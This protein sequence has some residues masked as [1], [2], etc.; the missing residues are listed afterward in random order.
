MST[1]LFIVAGLIVLVIVT[2]WVAYKLGHGGGESQAV[3]DLGLNGTIK[4]PGREAIP[5][6]PSLVNNELKAPEPKAAPAERKPNPTPVAPPSAPGTDPRVSGLNYYL[7]ASGLDKDGAQKIADFLTE[8]GLQSA[9]AVDRKP[10]GSN[11]PGSYVV[12]VT[13]GIKPEEYKTRAAART[14]VET[15]VSR[16]GKVWQKERKGKT[17]FSQAYWQRYSN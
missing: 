10:T 6:N 14:E 8:N 11:N 16:L 4:E 1:V 15:Q 12:F 9:A 13:R 2:W 3:K 17:D 7:L 5:V